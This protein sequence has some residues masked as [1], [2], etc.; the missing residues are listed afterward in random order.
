MDITQGLNFISQRPLNEG[1][2]RLS[3][4]PILF[5]VQGERLV[6]PI[7]YK[8]RFFLLAKSLPFQGIH[9]DIQFRDNSKSP[10]SITDTFQHRL[11]FVFV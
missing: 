8:L 11:V 3:M 9:V 10:T 7:W 6:V 5:S 2:A 4:D 1:E